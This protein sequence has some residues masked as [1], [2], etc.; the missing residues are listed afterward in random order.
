MRV[1]VYTGFTVFLLLFQLSVYL[2]DIGE[3]SVLMLD[4]VQPLPWTFWK[5]PFQAITAKLG[6]KL[7][8]SLNLLLHRLFLDHDIIFY[9]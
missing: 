2:V 4:E 9:F 5:L 8:C 7:R 3:F 6:C 1:A